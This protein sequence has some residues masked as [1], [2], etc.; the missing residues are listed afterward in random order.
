MKIVAVLTGDVNAS[1]Q[2]GQQQARQL[3]RL[4]RSCY[5]DLAT[6]MPNYGIDHF[7]CF[8]GDSWQFVVGDP[9]KAVD[10]YLDCH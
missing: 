6:A 1:S 7:T 5:Q 8:R 3:E 9:T 2:L 4:L 10:P